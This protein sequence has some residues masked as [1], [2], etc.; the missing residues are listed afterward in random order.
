[1]RYL[2]DTQAVIWMLES[3]PKLSNNAS[4]AIKNIQNELYV[5]IA[6]LW[7]MTIKRS[8]G[9]LNIKPSLD[10]I[11]KELHRIRI[12]IL[13]VEVPHLKTLQTLA[14]HHKDP[15]DRLLISQAITETLTLIS[16]DGEFE[17][18]PVKVFW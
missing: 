14:Y 3:D 9:K 16:V 13:P 11:Q 17:K 1:M 7:E 18:Y 15:F 2:L 4:L 10:D 12:P 5:S 8:L 6:S